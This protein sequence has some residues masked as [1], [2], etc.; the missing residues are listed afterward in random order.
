MKILIIGGDAAGMT[1]A[2]QIR[3][4]KPEWT[5]TV[6]E[7]GHYTSY[8]AC[9]IPYYFA[10][11]VGAREDLVVVSPD[12]FRQKRGIDLRT[13]WEALTIDP[14]AKTVAAR[15]ESGTEESVG[16]DRL[17][18]ATGASAVL[19]PWSGVDLDGVFPLRNLHDTESV[20]ELLRKSPKRCVIVGAGYV[21]LEM[22][23]AFRRRGMEVAVVE[24]L[25]GLMGGA[26]AKVTELALDVMRARGIRVELDT[27]VEGFAGTNG[28]L[29]AVETDQGR[30][31]AD[32][33]LISL[34]VRPNVTVAKE[35]GI[36]LGETGAI[37]VDDRQ[38]TGVDGVY[39]AG[40]CAEAWHLV[41]EKPAYI[42][43]AL[44]ANRQGRVAGANICGDDERFPGVIGSAVTRV[45]DLVIARTGIDEVTARREAIDYET[46]QATA[47]SKAHYFPGHDPLWVE[48]LFR[49]DDRRVIGAWLVGKDT[50][51]GKRS[52]ILATAITAG[53]TIDQV[54]SLD[55]CYA[56]PFAPVWDPV[57]QAANKARFQRSK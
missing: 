52:D 41:L 49:S 36:P 47:P 20:E 50:S 3:R 56:P 42:P 28:R 43:L 57:L 17:L 40:D 24:K 44:T 12:E 15:T 1:A 53:M 5:V 4:R 2:T 51:A 23:E 11:D 19:P 46:V 33:A 39:A 30:I 54:A 7:K 9:G 27:S 34:G 21:G 26:S 16:Y 13:G 8:A 38:R 18:I 48:I 31:E 55:L 37:R 22:A 25:S 14:V 6:L 10:G 45:F 35:S 32:I 29:Q